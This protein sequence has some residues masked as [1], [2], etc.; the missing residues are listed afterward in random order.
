MR[1]GEETG[2]RALFTG[3]QIELEQAFDKLAKELKAQYF[4][5]YKSTNERYDGS[6]R[7]IEVK[8]AND[9]DGMKVRAKRGYVAS[10]QT[11]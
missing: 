11:K 5:T 9:R 10:A 7:R 1:L 2:G 3:D 8:L 4:V 6:F